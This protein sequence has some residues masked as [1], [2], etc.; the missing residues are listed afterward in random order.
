MKKIALAALSASLLAA[1]ASTSTEAPVEEVAAPTPVEIGNAS[2]FERAMITVEAL[3]EAG[4]T[5]TAIDRL[6]QLLG[7]AD[8]S[9]EEKAATHFRRGV[10]RA[11]S[12]GYDT[13]GAIEDFELVLEDYPDSE[14][15]LKT[16]AEL[17][18]ARGKATGLNFIKENPESS[19]EERFKAHF[20]L[21]EHE[22]AIDLMLSSGLTPDNDI[23]VAMYNIGYLCEGDELTGPAYDVAEPNG[24]NRML[25]F[26]DFGK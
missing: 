10:L 4:N 2:E 12:E 6:T 8:L 20:E 22:E 19:R 11:S 17:D 26:C 1:C 5:Q 15:A 18:M 13:W 9:D 14:A 7:F 21:G 3:E 16:Q 24:S 23:L 25:R